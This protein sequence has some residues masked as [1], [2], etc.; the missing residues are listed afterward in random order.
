MSHDAELRD[1]LV[2]LLT[3]PWAHVTADAALGEIPP[4]H[5]G[6]KP[7]GHPHT[8]WQLLEHL[9]ICNHIFSSIIEGLS[10]GEV[11]DRPARTQDVKP[12]PEVGPEVRPA[13]EESC[14]AWLHGLEGIEGLNTD[15]RFAHPWFGPLNAAGWQALSAL[16][17]K[18]HRIQL[19]RI[20]AGLTGSG[21]AKE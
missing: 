8:I 16:H 12:S 18:V 9:R 11:P 17:M 7:P 15:T 13:Y 6:V 2:R 3:A 5:R 19:E 21:P 20:L 14:E 1:H 4:E 10:R